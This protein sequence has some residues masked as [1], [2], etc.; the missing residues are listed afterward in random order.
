MIE[1]GEKVNMEL[2]WSDGWSIRQI[3]I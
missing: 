3:H 1:N 2:D